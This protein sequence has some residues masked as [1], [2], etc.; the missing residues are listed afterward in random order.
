M[1]CCVC[2]GPAYYLGWGVSEVPGCFP[3][4][5]R[6]CSPRTAPSSEA[7]PRA[8]QRAP[9]GMCSVQAKKRGP[10]FM[11]KLPSA[12]SRLRRDTPFIANIRFKNDLPEVRGRGL[13]VLLRYPGSTAG[14]E[15]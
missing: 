1:P 9:W 10:E 5:S 4:R 13:G 8:S 7:I 6:C 3:P 14:V 15:S 12:P 11:I 2:R